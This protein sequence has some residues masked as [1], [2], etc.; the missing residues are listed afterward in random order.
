MEDVLG[1]ILFAVFIVCVVAL[2][3]GVTWTVVRLSPLPKS[4]EAKTPTPTP[5]S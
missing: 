2:A 4:A 3:A 1:L 5:D